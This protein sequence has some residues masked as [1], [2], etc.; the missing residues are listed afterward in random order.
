MTYDAKYAGYVARQEI[1][2]APAAAAGGAANPGGFRL[3]RG[4]ASAG[5]GPGEVRPSPPG[6]SCPG[7]PD[8]RDHAGRL[9]GADGAF[10]EEL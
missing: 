4:C 1:D 9:G 10:L 8:Q 6:G 3:S 5:R 2:I 7:R